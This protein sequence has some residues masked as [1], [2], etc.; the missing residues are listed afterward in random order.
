[1]RVLIRIQIVNVSWFYAPRAGFGVSPALELYDTGHG[2]AFQMPAAYSAMVRSLENL[3]E[4]GHIQD[5]LARPGIRV[6]IQLGKPLVRLQVRV[7]VRQV[8][9]VV[10]VRQQRVAQA[11]RKCPVRGG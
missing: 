10:P 3:P 11:E 4:A 9:V 7:Q 5:R 8:H 2:S 1:M 6:G